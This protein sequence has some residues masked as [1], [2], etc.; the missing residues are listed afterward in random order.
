MASDI[1]K[2]S[3]TYRNFYAKY[4]DFAAKKT[5]RLTSALYLVSE[6]VPEK[7][8]L[9][10]LLREK[11]LTTM[12]DVFSIVVF[13]KENKEDDFLKIMTE[14]SELAAL[15]RIAATSGFISEMNAGIL[16]KEYASLHGFFESQCRDL[17]WQKFGKEVVLNENFFEKKE[18]AHLDGAS[19]RYDKGQ[20]KRH[21]IDKGH[22]DVVYPVASEQWATSSAK[23]RIQISGKTTET[24]KDIHNEN[25]VQ[26]E[27]KKTIVELIKNSNGNAS[28]KDISSHVKGCSEKTLQRDIIALMQKGILKKTGERRWSRYSLV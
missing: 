22:N 6:L 11:G 7:E 10:T 26:E 8:P 15:L 9:K 24:T 27:R 17:E 23:N 13:A 3:A 5:E 28:I 12:S 19:G 16:Q 20:D 2:D 25:F 4:M 18:W 14:I 21:Q 1:I